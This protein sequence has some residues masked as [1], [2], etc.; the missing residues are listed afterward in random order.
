MKMKTGGNM[1]MRIGGESKQL[2]RRKE[3][4]EGEGKRRR[5]EIKGEKEGRRR[6]EKGK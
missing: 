3:R 1:I 2:G 4:R 6:Q 5:M